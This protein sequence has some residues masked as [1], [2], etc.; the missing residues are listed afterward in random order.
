MD[1]VTP[2]ADTS[3]DALGRET[4]I[5]RLGRHWLECLEE[6][7]EGLRPLVV[8]QSLEYPGWP[9]PDFCAL[10]KRNGFRCVG[11]RRPGYGRCPP[12]ADIDGQVSLLSKFLNGLGHDS[13]V[14]VCMGT[15]NT[16]GYRLAG[17][18]KVG[19]TVL[20]NCCFNYDPMAEIRPDWFARHIEQTLTSVTGARL[21]LMGLKG[22]QGIFGKYWVTEN[23][24]QKSPGDLAYLEAN[25][26]LFS[27]AMDCLHDDL[28]IHTFIMELRGTLKE[29]SFLQDGCFNYRNVLSVS[30][31][32]TSEQWKAA[33]RAEAA[34]VGAPLHFL[35]SGDALVVYASASQFMDLLGQYA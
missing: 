11:V 7:G 24:M 31:G 14:L 28:D 29:D 30:G 4:G 16:F 21:A 19:L 10:A 17:H 23:F 32:E 9:S 27:D 33:I 25:R 13:I 20:A 35:P 12:L 5:Y 15:S 34:R 22:A 3:R 8:L 26:E 2:P 1:N 18:P 6:K